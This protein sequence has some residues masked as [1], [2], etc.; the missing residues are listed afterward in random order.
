M[1]TRQEKIRKVLMTDKSKLNRAICGFMKT[2][3]LE[4][5][6]DVGENKQV[7]DLPEPFRSDFINSY[8]KAR[9]HYERN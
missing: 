5:L 7:N 9:A 6:L 2:E 4:Y 3:S 8:K 1:T